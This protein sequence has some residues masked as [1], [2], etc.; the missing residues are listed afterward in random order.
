MPETMKCGCVYEHLA[1]WSYEKVLVELCPGHLWMSFSPAE[2][3]G[4]L[5]TFPHYRRGDAPF[6]FTDDEWDQMIQDT[7]IYRATQ[8]WLPESAKPRL[9]G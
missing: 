8:G 9:E 1:S 7:N 2:R 5:L 6:D 3:Y 4:I